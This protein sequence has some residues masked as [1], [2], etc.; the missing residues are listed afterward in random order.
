[1]GEANYLG[2]DSKL[3]EVNIK[4]LLSSTTPF[5]LQSIQWI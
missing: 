5:N 3:Y 4:G 2:E 1:M